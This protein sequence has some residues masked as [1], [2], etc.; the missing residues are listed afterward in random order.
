VKQKMVSKNTLNEIEQE[1]CSYLLNVDDMNYTMLCEPFVFGNKSN[2]MSEI[3]LQRASYLLNLDDI[4]YAMLD[5]PLVIRNKPAMTPNSYIGVIGEI[6][7][8]NGLLYTEDNKKITE[9]VDIQ[10]QIEFPTIK[11]QQLRPA[12]LKY[13]LADD[14]SYSE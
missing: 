2:S 12:T 5:E 13:E 14:P 11:F 6:N 9:L 10:S 1:M 4:N 7:L 8:V 3:E